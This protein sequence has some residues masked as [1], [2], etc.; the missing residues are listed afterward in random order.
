MRS[1][2]RLRIDAQLV[3]VAGDVPL[4]AERYDRELKD[5]FAIQDEISRAIVNKLRLTLGT[6]QRRYDTNLEAYQPYLKAR[7]LVG[8]RG[9]LP[10]QQAVKLFEQ[11]IAG[12]P[13]SPLPMRGWLTR[14][15]PRP[16]TFQVR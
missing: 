4:W 5:I 7:V 12:I 1:G 15:R 14:T 2:K 9:F 16:R 6:G 11:A 8:R 3:Q 13:R 10:A